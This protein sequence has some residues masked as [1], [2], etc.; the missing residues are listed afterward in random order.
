MPIKIEVLPEK[1]RLVYNKIKE[2]GG[3]NGGILIGGT[4]M[5]LQ[6][7]HRLSEDLDFWFPKKH[8]RQAGLDTLISVLAKSCSIELITP[9]KD[10][11]RSK[12]NGFDLLDA[13]RDY[14]ID[15]TRVTFFHRSDAA[16]KL[17]EVLPTIQDA[18]LTIM[19]ADG[20][21]KM[22]SYVITQRVKSR[23][24]FDLR[25]F[26]DH[27]KSIEDILSSAREAVPS[28]FSEELI[29]SVLTGVVPLDK[30]DEGIHSVSDGV[31]M[32][33]IYRFFEDRINDYE[34][35]KFTSNAPSIK[36][37]RPR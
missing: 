18:A 19:S 4:A 3:I 10:I 36:S 31:V 17:F 8:L 24:L 16:H 6:C 21:F 15:G 25:Y 27:G 33:D 20:V 30:N 26:L 35:D 13:A 9:Q 28:E 29:K 1:T 12:I 32:D 2:L 5:A 22:K 7:G 23:D 11:V 34:S 14:L 37:L